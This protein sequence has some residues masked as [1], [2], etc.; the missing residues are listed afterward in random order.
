MTNVPGIFAAGNVA[1][2]YDLVDY[3]SESAEYAAQ[4]AVRYIDGKA[5]TA[6]PI[7]VLAGDSIG[8]LIPNSYHPDFQG[9]GITLYLRVTEEKFKAELTVQ[10]GDTVL[11]TVRKVVVRPAQMVV[12][13][14][15]REDLA[16]LNGDEP[17]VISM[18]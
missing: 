12:I 2:V 17:I 14:L 4:G 9:D 13:H 6:S 18:K 5:P 11:K 10:Q 15:S 1:V 8:A 16:K 3:V 7:P